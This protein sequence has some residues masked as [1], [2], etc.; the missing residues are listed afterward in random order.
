MNPKGFAVQAP[1]CKKN[2]NRRNGLMAFAKTNQY[3]NHFAARLL[4]V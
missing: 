1:G 4:I 2:C 3:L